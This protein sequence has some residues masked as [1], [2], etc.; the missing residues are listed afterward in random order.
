MTPLLDVHLHGWKLGASTSKMIGYASIDLKGCLDD[1]YK[2]NNPST[3]GT[4]QTQ[5]DVKGD[6]A[7]P[8]IKSKTKLNKDPKSQTNLQKRES[9][10]RLNTQPDQTD[11]NK[12]PRIPEGSLQDIQV[13]LKEEAKSPTKKD[14][15]KSQQQ[16]EM[17]QN[18]NPQSQRLDTEEVISFSFE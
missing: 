17:Q 5:L 15:T 14:L 9:E 1:F 7:S 6:P 11:G 12:K 10:I 2:L 13:E 3:V 16:V 18:D 4:V 8:T